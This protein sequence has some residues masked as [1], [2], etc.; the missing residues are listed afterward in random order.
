MSATKPEAAGLTDVLAAHRLT[1][2]SCTCMAWTADLTAATLMRTVDQHRA[3]VAVEVSRWLQA[4]LLGDE[5]VEAHRWLGGYFCSCGHE[6]NS[7]RGFNEHPMAAALD[8]VEALSTEE[9][10]T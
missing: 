4:V 3:H 1:A 8:R 7:P 9:A 10:G 5:V 2:Y 6:L